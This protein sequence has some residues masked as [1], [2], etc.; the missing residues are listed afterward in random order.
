LIDP[1]TLYIR[2]CVFYAIGLIGIWLSTGD[3]W[4]AIPVAIALIV[5]RKSFGLM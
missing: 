4:P 5:L 1:D 2:I 3:C